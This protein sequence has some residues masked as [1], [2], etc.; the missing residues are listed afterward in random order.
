M[1]AQTLAEAL[2]SKGIK[3]QDIADYFGINRCSVNLVIHGRQ[4]SARIMEHIDRLMGWSS[5]TARRMARRELISRL[6]SSCPA[7]KKEAAYV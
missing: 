2:S 5:G 1:A 4:S 3:Q 7:I 6:G